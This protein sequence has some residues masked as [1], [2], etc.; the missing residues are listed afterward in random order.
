VITFTQ[1]DFGRTLTSNGDGT[2]HGWGS[3]QLV[4]GGPV[5]GRKIYGTMPLLEIGG[6]DDVSGGRMIPTISADQYAATLARWFGVAES[7]LA[8]I[9]P[10]LPNFAVQDLGFLA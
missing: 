1:S 7:E 10:H 4:M 5:L 3:H 6:V 2:D 8:A 9:A